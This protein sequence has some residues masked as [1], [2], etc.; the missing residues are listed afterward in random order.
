MNLHLAIQTIDVF[1]VWAT[2]M[3][4]VNISL[5]KGGIA[6]HPLTRIGAFSMIW[7]LTQ[8]TFSDLAGAGD[9]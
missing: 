1:A 4:F 8:R 9:T 3:L 6:I 5:H 7:P 2:L